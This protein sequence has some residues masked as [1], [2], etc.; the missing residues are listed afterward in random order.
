M[1]QLDL[2]PVVVSDDVELDDAIEVLGKYSV[3]MIITTVLPSTDHADYLRSIRS[4]KPDINR[5]KHEHFELLRH[6]CIAVESKKPLKITIDRRRII[7]MA[8]EQKRRIDQWCKGENGG[9][10][11]QIQGTEPPKHQHWG[12]TR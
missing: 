5:Y 12:A 10:D 8:F 6:R 3:E 2:L 1:T 11:W 7:A 9:A 4:G